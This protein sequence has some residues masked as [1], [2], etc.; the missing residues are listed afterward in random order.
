MQQK[1]T[2]RVNATPCINVNL[3]KTALKKNQEYLT[4]QR[5][6]GERGRQGRGGK[7]TDIAPP[8]P[9]CHSSTCLSPPRASKWGA[10]FTS[11]SYVVQRQAEHV[12]LYE[13]TVPKWLEYKCLIEA[14]GRIIIHLKFVVSKQNPKLMGKEG[15]YMWTVDGRRRSVYMNS[16]RKTPTSV[17]KASKV[18]WLMSQVVKFKDIHP[19]W[20]SGRVD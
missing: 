19:F 12:V 10:F 2:Q 20:S 17:F 18:S 13:E 11:D 5:S 14:M 9:P 3:A 15:R 6:E 4:Q 1:Q 7:Q 16:S 8:H